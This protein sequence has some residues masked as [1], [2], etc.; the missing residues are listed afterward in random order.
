MAV[1]SLKK[2]S[3]ERSHWRQGE[4]QMGRENYGLQEPMGISLIDMINSHLRLKYAI[5]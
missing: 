4:C 2:V 5:S 1:A 3:S